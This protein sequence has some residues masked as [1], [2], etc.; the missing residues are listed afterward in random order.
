MGHAALRQHDA[1]RVA[2]R[3]VHVHGD[4]AVAGLRE[5]H[6][7]DVRVDQRELPLPVRAH[8]VAAAH[9][10][11]LHPVRPVDV[12]VHQRQR[13]LD[14]ARVE[15]LVG[16]LEQFHAPI[17]RA[18]EV[19]CDRRSNASGRRP[20]I[21]S[22]RVTRTEGIDETRTCERA[23]LR[24]RLGHAGGRGR[25]RSR[26]A[27]RSDRGEADGR[28][29]ADVGRAHA[30][31]HRADRGA[32]QARAGPER[33]HAAQRGGVE[34]R[35][36]AGQGAPRRSRARAR[37]RP[38]GPAQGPDRR[39]GHVHVGGQLLAAQLLPGDRLRRGQEAARERRRDPR[40]ARPV[41]VRELL[42]QP[43]VGLQQPHRPGPERRSTPTR[44]RAAP[45]RAPARPAPPRSRC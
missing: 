45:R 11:A 41:R 43:A 9:A 2:D 10:A 37:A 3:L 35:R 1:V 40:Q 28:G 13:G 20:R 5:A 19:G 8:R 15:G 7:L 17:L 29:Q 39:Q 25:A 36:A 6:R 14:V 44:T 18:V 4:A 33:G 22:P 30:R 24:A 23:G 31:V 42:R 34:G 12:V 26:D 27:R 21:A 38:A 32:E 16:A